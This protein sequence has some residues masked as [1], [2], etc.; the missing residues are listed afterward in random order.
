MA[1]PRTA[2]GLADEFQDP[3]HS[4]SIEERGQVPAVTAAGSMS[5]QDDIP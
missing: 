1:L 2:C 4:H 5:A 3:D